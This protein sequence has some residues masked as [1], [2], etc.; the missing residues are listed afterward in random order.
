MKIRFMAGEMARLHNISKQTLIYYDKIGLF[1]PDETDDETG[2]RYYALEQCQDLDVIICLKNFG[3]SLKEIKDY[4]QKTTTAERIH[5][6]EDKENC[7]RKKI[8]EIR[9]AKK[10]LNN[11]ISSLKCRMDT[12]PFEIGIKR[13]SER[14]IVSQRVEH[15]FDEYQLEIAIKRLFQNNRERD[16]TGI[17]ELLVRVESNTPGEVMFK[18]AALQVENKTGECFAEADYGFIVHKGPIQSLGASRKKLI[19]SIETSDYKALGNIHIEKIL[20]DALAV[21][22][23]NEYLI[24]IQIPVAKKE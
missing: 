18:T 12:V 4:L 16:D 8:E 14:F 20:L 22:G 3:M 17:H 7:M 10:R 5:L 9:R 1:Q 19:A 11:T 2:Y 15:P 24:E 21:S 13:E 23:H 6:L